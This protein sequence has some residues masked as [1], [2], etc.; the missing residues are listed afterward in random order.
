MIHLQGLMPEKGFTKVQLSECWTRLLVDG[1]VK[2][3]L[4]LSPSE[5]PFS[6]K[7][8]SRAQGTFYETVK[9]NVVIL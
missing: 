2:K 7:A 4:Q 5:A 1:V 9:L 6:Q 8:Q 3:G